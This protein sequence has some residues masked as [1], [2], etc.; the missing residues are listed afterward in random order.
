MIHDLVHGHEK[1]EDLSPFGEVCPGG[2]HL[3]FDVVGDVHVED[4]VRREV[5]GG[6]LDGKSGGGLWGNNRH[7]WQSIR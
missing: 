2:I 1:D 5:V 6:K 4:W 7:D 3:K